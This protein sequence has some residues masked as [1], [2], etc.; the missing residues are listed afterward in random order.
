[1][2]Q[3]SFVFQKTR[4]E[5]NPATVDGVEY[6][7]IPGEDLKPRT[8]YVVSVESI[9]NDVLSDSSEEHEFT[10]RKCLPVSFHLHIH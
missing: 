10:T 1:M 2:T 6:Y 7:E 4:Y 5:V 3:F 8:P 9:W